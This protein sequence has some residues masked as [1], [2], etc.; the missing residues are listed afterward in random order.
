MKATIDGQPIQI[1]GAPIQVFFNYR[2]QETEL[3]EGVTTLRAVECV[4]RPFPQTKEDEPQPYSTGIALCSPLDKFDKSKGRLLAWK[5]AVQGE[6]GQSRFTREQRRDLWS[7]FTSA[8]R[9]PDDTKF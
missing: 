1:E 3:R 8:C 6:S 9:L 4:I 5:R 7:W 2:E